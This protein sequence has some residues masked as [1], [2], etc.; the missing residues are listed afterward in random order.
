VTFLAALCIG[1]CA[2]MVA[3][4]L[5]G[6]P[7][8]GGSSRAG[9]PWAAVVASR[10]RAG[11]VGFQVWLSQAGAAVTPAQF[12]A[13]SAGVGASTFLILLAISRTP[14][15]A[16]LPALAAFA[17]PY[18][19][20]AA[21]R[22][23]QAEARGAAWPD[24]LRYLVGVLGAGVSTLHDALAELARSGPAPLRAPMARYTRM[25]GRVGNRVA[26]ETVR[27]ELADPLSDPVLL[28]LA[29][30][31]EEG[32]GTALRVLHDLGSQI[33]ADVQLSEKIRTLQ[34][35]S[36]VATWGCFTLPYGLLLFLCATNG[37]YRQFFSQPVGLVMVLAGSCTS[38]L[39]LVASRWLVRP[40]ATSSRVFVTEGPAWVA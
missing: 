39:G 5:A 34:T 15:V 21:Q 11:G 22:R 37:A 2:W 36:R 4:Q 3:R 33:T 27:A 8:V 7:P 20:W 14:V 9:A 18:A 10:R 13:V 17:A 12:W 31:I 32:T 25:A 26:L 40:I 16:A 30:A 23:H 29:G 28:A 19:Y 24:A 6:G 38:V 1:A 35:Q